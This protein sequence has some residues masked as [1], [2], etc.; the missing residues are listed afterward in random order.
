MTRYQIGNNVTVMEEEAKME[1]VI[2]VTSF[3][4]LRQMAAQVLA[5]QPGQQETYQKVEGQEPVGTV[6]ATVTYPAETKPEP[7]VKPI[8]IAV[9][10]AKLTEVH[11]ACSPNTVKGL[12]ASFGVDKLTAL[13][14]ALRGE[15]MVKA[16][17]L[18]N[19]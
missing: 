18:L 4:E 17:A 16:E 8:D 3:E 9:V 7:P 11:K 12:L 13:D 10:R 14:P 15:V 19:G 2:K 5:G 1:I 6:D